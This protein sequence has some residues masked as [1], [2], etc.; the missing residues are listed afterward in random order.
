MKKP[1]LAEVKERFETKEALVDEL[2]KLLEQPEDETQDEWRSRLLV[3]PNAKLL[4]LH[5]NGTAVSDRFG[6]R[7][8]LLDAICELKFAGRKVE[9]AWR[10]KIARW[11]NGRLLDLHGSLRR[12]AKKAAA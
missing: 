9:D 3:A 7:D 4:R 8:A 5:A 2:V 1:P 11:S 6:G 10:D 12:A